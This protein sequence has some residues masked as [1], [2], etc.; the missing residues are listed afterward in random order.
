MISPYVRRRR[1]AAELI[2]LREERGYSAARLAEAVGISRQTISRLENGHA[3]PNLDEV[4]RILDVLKVGKQPWAKIMTIARD[5]Q[6]RGWWEKYAD[7]MGPRQALYANLEA[8]AASIH[9]YQMNLLPGLLQ[10][11]TF[12]ET[13]THADRAVYNEQ[14]NPS[15]AVEA[16]VARQRVLQRPGGPTYEVIV[17]EL[18]VR[19]FAAPVDIVLAQIDHIVDAGHRYKKITIRVL[20]LAASIDGYA[21]PRSAFFT[22][23][24]PD[25]EDP[26]VVAVDTI[27]S[28]LV[29]TDPTQVGHYLDLYRRLREAALAPND[30]LDFLAT[31]AEELHNKTGS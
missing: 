21:I 14:F 27:T 26:V 3:R 28:D 29:L 16:R 2:R 22:Y 5:A 1:L 19:R 9:E 6:E 25:P 30:S 8:G 17:D 12:T 10:I 15:R 7:E 31:V 24:Y 20:P 18:A 11:P 23:R 13:R 4:M